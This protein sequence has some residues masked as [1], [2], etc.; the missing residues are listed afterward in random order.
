[1]SVQL[2]QA[3]SKKRNRFSPQRKME[4]LNDVIIDPDPT[5]GNTDKIWLGSN[6]THYNKELALLAA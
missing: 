6:L 1:M 2:I 3:E 5:S 4:I